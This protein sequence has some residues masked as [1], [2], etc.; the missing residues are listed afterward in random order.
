[1]LD[2][3]AGTLQLGLDAK[4]SYDNDGNLIDIHGSAD[5]FFNFNNANDWHLNVGLD[6][7]RDR[8]LTARLF[9]LF[10]SYSYVMLNS[11]QLAMGAWV[12]FQQNWTF[13]PLSVGIEAWIDGNARVSWK[14]AHFLRRSGAAR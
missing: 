14:P 12:G 13:G 8:R 3:R 11:Q 1:V 7:P 4:Y 10:D 9:K 5:G 6:E 2:G